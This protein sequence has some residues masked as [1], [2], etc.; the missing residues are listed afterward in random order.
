MED[1]KSCRNLSWDRPVQKLH[2]LEEHNEQVLKKRCRPLCA[3]EVQMNKDQV[4]S[5][6]SS[7]V[8]EDVQTDVPGRTCTRL[9][10]TIRTPKRFYN[11][12]SYATRCENIGSVLVLL[13]VQCRETSVSNV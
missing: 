8:G 7:F 5:D 10:R 13:E 11:C 4:E 1:R 3:T 9:G 6:C 12:K 2:L